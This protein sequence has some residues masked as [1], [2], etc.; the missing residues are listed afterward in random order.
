M[1]AAQEM[2]TDISCQATGWS[3][4]QR[5]ELEESSFTARGSHLESRVVDGLTA[6]IQSQAL[7]MT[8]IRLFEP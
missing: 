5:F 2:L 7:L 3:R 8:R 4:W 6:R 1:N